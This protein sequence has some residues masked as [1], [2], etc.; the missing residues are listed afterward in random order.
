MRILHFS[1]FHLR[2][3]HEGKRSLDILERMLDAIRM[4]NEK[5]PIDMVVFT[6][7]LVDKAGAE[8]ECSYAEA[9]QDFRIKV[10]DRIVAITSIPAY[11]F[12]IVGGNHEIE[13]GLVDESEHE[14][15][16]KISDE[17]SLEHYMNQKDIADK[18]QSMNT[19]V[20]FQREYYKSVLDPKNCEYEE[21]L[22]H[23]TLTFNVDGGQKVGVSLLNSA[24]MCYD[25]S[26]E[27][28]IAMGV[29]QLN[30]SWPKFKDCISIAIA[31]H[32]PTFLNSYDQDEVTRVLLQHF[33]FSRQESK[34]L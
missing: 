25:N 1:D 27:K 22:F 28:K 11:R 18:V 34:I 8:F 17:Q 12:L 15:Q 19:F 30:T 10:I 14:K 24:W 9:L 20:N 29:Q 32:H 6:G 31:H 3:G 4:I 2:S 26:D 13:R 21:G 5:K 33:D 23:R 16:V 7:D